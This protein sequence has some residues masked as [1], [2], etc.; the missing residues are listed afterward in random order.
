MLFN[1]FLIPFWTEPEKEYDSVFK[2]GTSL[3]QVCNLELL[4]SQ[5]KHL[6]KKKSFCSYACKSKTN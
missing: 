1:L 4:M 3:S 6:N 5:A 2:A